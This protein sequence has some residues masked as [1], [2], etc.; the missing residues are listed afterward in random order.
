MPLAKKDTHSPQ[1][2]PL[3]PCIRSAISLP[4]GCPG[5]E[6]HHMAEV[7]MKMQQLDVSRVDIESRFVELY[8]QFLTLS[9]I[10]YFKMK[11]LI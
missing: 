10:G 1:W 4:G 7:E 9:W 2:H 6:L 11:C 5:W 3:Y 8:H